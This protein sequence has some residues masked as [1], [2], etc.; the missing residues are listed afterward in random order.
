VGIRVRKVVTVGHLVHEYDEIICTVHQGGHPAS[1]HGPPVGG[2]WRRSFART[3]RLL[4]AEKA[5]WTECLFVCRTS[6]GPRGN[7][8][9]YFCPSRASSHCFSQAPGRRAPARIPLKFFNW[10]TKKGPRPGR[11]ELA[12][13]IKKPILN[14]DGAQEEAAGLLLP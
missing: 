3:T 1:H 14:W 7:S 5:C 11:A 8:L 4:S 13:Y 2:P 9:G 10:I 6:P 12:M